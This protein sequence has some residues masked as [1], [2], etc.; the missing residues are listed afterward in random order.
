MTATLARIDSV[1]S[2]TLARF[3][4]QNLEQAIQVSDLLARAGDLIP[5]HLQGKPAAVLATLLAGAEL[6]IGMMESFRAIYLVKGKVGFYSD[7]M[8]AKAKGHARC[9]RF[10]MLESTPQVATFE[11]EE[12][13]GKVTRMSFTMAEAA[14][15]GLTR[16][17]KY[18]TSPAAMLR[19]RCVSA[20]VKVVYPDSF[21]G[22]YSMEEVQEIEAMEKELN[23]PPATTVS[24]PAAQPMASGVAAATAKLQKAKEAAPAFRVVDVKPEETEEQATARAKAP[25]ADIPRL[26]FGPDKGTPFQALNI[27]QL[28]DYLAKAREHLK[29]DNGGRWTPL[30]R[31][32]IT[33]LEEEIAARQ[34]EMP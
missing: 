10:D 20:L 22:A 28:A 13:G 32:Q 34:M 5:A 29:T 18:K 15:Q 25:T 6:G 33:E 19:A 21:F 9:V 24:A 4:P 31:R 8:L 1:P 7:F 16:N 11:T 26:R 3:Q 23:P 27:G 30:L 2:N 14:E 17:E 12:K